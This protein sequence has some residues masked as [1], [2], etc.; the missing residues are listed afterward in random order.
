[1]PRRGLSLVGFMSEAQALLHYRTACVSRPDATDAALR[2][3]WAAARL[4]L[5]EPIASAG[6]PSVLPLPPSNRSHAEALFRLPWIASWAESVCRQHGAI[7]CADVK[8][9][10]IDPLLAFQFTVD[11]EHSD[12]YCASLKEPHSMD[13]LLSI[14]LPLAPASID[15]R[16]Q[17]TPQS[18]ILKTQDLNLSVQSAG[19][20]QNMG[21]GIVFDPPLPIV[22]VV[23]L[24]GKFH[25]FN[26]FHRAVGLSQRG[27]TH[28]PCIV[29]DVA[30]AQS[31][32]IRTDGSTF[33]ESLLASSNPPTLG[34]FSR[35]R[36]SEVRLRAASRIVHVSWADYLWY[37]E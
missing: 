29:R 24:K 6:E 12:R 20:I 18:V 16:L 27:F 26:G 2:D 4:K 9:V 19:F 14:C 1:M 22:Q 3:A 28:M 31:A 23:R 5:G 37:E 34:H 13:Q 17:S 10:E 36:A 11:V 30:D 33:T 15:F 21:A 25:V 8:L 32:G 35:G 7:S